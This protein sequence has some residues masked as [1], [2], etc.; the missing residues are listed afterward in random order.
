MDPTIHAEQ[1]AG[2][3]LLVGHTEDCCLL[4][5]TLTP[6]APLSTAI[7]ASATIFTASSRAEELPLL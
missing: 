7:A 4:D 1:M 6:G 2:C 5:P 3:G